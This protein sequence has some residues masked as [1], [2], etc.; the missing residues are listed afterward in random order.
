MTLTG[1]QSGSPTKLWLRLPRS[2]TKRPRRL[3]GKGVRYAISPCYP[4]PHVSQYPKLQSSDV[5]ELLK[6]LD[7]LAFVGQELYFD[8]DRLFHRLR[9]HSMYYVPPVLNNLHDECGDFVRDVLVTSRACNKYMACCCR[10]YDPNLEIEGL[11]T[12]GAEPKAAYDNF[13]KQYEKLRQI[14]VQVDSCWEETGP[15]IDKELHVS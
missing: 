13:L 14:I 1:K 4:M 15:L 8:F 5:P 2:A 12:D 6:L 11:P 10:F 9:A 3:L 7:T